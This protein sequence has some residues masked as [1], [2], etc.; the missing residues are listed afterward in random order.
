MKFRVIVKFR[1]FEF[2]SYSEALIFRNANG[3]TIYVKEFTSWKK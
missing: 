1:V 2:S 3:G